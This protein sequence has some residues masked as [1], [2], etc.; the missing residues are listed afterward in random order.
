MNHSQEVNK[1]EAEARMATPKQLAYI[2]RLRTDIGITIDK[3]IGELTVSEASELIE[4]L[5]QKTNGTRARPEAKPVKRTDFRN[6][7]RLGMA[8]KCVY[9][10]WVSSGVNISKNKKNFIKNVLDTYR[11]INEIPEKALEA[12]TT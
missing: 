5:L 2:E 12:P 9:R 10:N 8:F 1:M 7:A 11:L 4:E 3:P 6:G